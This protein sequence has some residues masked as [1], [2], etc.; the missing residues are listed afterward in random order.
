MKTLFKGFLIAS[1]MFIGVAANAQT[2]I[3]SNVGTIDVTKAE[4]NGDQVDLAY[5]ITID[6]D[7]Q[8]IIGL[9][10]KK[11]IVL[12][13]ALAEGDFKQVIECLVISPAK[14]NARSAWLE[15]RVEDVTNNVRYFNAKADE[16][17]VIKS[18]YTLKAKDWTSPDTRLTITTQEL[19]KAECL[20]RLNGPKQVAKLKATDI[21]PQWANLNPGDGTAEKHLSTKLYYPV[22][23]TKEVDDYLENA[24]ALQILKT[25]DSPNFDVTAIKINGWASPEATVPY[26]QKLSEGRA[27]TM[28][29]IISNRYSFPE[30]V[31]TVSGNGEYWDLVEAYVAA[32]D[33]PA[34]KKWAE[35]KFSNL[36]SREAALKQLS[37]YKDIFNTVYPRSRFADCDVTYKLVN[38]DAAAVRSIYNT[39]PEQLSEAEYVALGS[40]NDNVD[41]AVVEKGLTYYPD[42]EALNNL[43]AKAAVAEGNYR[44]AINYLQKAGN[45]REVLNN[46]GVCQMLL[47]QK[48]AATQSFQRAFGLPQATQNLREL[49]KVE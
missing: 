4:Y 7:V 25:L 32:S 48:E 41:K 11:G 1:L 13:T 16:P 15:D 29:E 30:A 26:N 21:V 44:E 8:N 24:Q 18:N 19:K 46:L 35:R 39:Y 40:L 9:K 49:R 27:A 43:A 42:S 2:R 34:L 5:T 45:S 3:Y 23:V 36:D 33:D 31:Y 22:N 14:G 17:L 38:F 6:P 37:A 47:G 20:V 12:T 28:K 10:G